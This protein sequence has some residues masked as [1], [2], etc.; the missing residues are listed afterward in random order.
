MTRFYFTNIFWNFNMSYNQSIN[1]CYSQDNV[2]NHESVHLK[3]IPE[4]YITVTSGL[5]EANP[6]NLVVVPLMY[7][8]Q[9]YGV[10]ELASFHAFDE[11]QT[12]LL[13]KTAE[14]VAA[15]LSAIKAL[16]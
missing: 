8:G 4:G 16:Q 1:G 7:E 15:T 3:S 2:E 12:N 11:H 6:D 14:S 13:E 10:I 9:V 5:G